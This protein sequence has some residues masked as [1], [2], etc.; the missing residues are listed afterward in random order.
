[1]QGKGSV[2][3]GL[4]ASQEVRYVINIGDVRDIN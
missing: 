1:M 4:R 2:I 3:E